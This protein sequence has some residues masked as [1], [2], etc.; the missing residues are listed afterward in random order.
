VVLPPHKLGQAEAVCFS[1]DGRSVFVTE[2]GARAA[3]LRYD[4]RY[5]NPYDPR[6]GMHKR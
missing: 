1:R 2:E 6:Q 4:L 5:P 3:L